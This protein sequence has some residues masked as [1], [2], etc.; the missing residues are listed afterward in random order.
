MSYRIKRVAHLTGINP[1]TL[2]AWERRYGLVAP[3]RT[4]SGYRL[5]T[6]EDV[7]MLSRI[8]ALVDDGLTIGEAISRVRRGADPLPADRGGPSV[9]EARFRMLEAL[10]SFDRRRAL[11]AYEEVLRL[12]PDRRVEEVLLPVLREVGE[13]WQAGECGVSEEHFGSALVRGR[14]AGSVGDLATACARGP[15]AVCAGVPGELREAGLMAA[16]IRLATRGWR[17]VYL[18]TNIPVEEVRRILQ[19]RRPA[20]FCTS[21]VNA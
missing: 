12:P 21:V 8:K 11:N 7:A 16:S 15:G 13:L 2:R 9:R 6:D 5:Y 1:A 3:D 14:P 4:D 20:M 10:L 19:L 17:V 18:G